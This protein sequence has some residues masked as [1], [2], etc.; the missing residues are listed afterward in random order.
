[1]LRGGAPG[2]GPEGATEVEA[3]AA[4]SWRLWA[5][6][7]FCDMSSAGGS[8]NGEDWG[9]VEIFYNYYSCTVYSVQCCTTVH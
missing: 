9:A 1:M 2:G 7:R 6:E 8:G 4:E 3:P 5:A